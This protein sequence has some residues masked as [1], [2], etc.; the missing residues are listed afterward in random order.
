VGFFAK[1]GLG[2]GNVNLGI[3]LYSLIQCLILSSTLAYLLVWLRRNRINAKYIAVVL[4]FFCLC[5]L[6]GKMAMSVWKEPIW[7][8]ALVLL[9]LKTLD[10]CIAPEKY[11]S[12]WKHI[13][14]I[15]LAAF[16]I[17]FFRN[18]GVYIIILVAACL[19]IAYQ[20]KSL[21]L[22][23][24]LVGLLVLTMVIQGPVYRSVG[25]RDETPV[26]SMGIPLQQVAWVINNNEASLS[27][28]QREYLCL[29]FSHP[30]QKQALHMSLALP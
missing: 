5:P 2:V 13:G 14:L 19:P 25:V 15:L 27:D 28:S 23:G 24:C 26:E 18:N 1:L 9:T 4:L 29:G 16:V 10:I 22:A 6:F 30:E 8:C 21:R 3:L 17:I 20:G 11:L 12:N 7:S